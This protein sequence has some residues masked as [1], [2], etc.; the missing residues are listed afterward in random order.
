MTAVEFTLCCKNAGLTV[1]EIN[2]WNIG[3]IIDYIRMK[4]K[5]MM[6][7]DSVY[8]DE[9]RYKQLKAIEPKV[10]EDYKKGLITKERYDKFK[11]QLSEWR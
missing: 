10:D 9:E 8:T 1:E 4:T 7:N 3:T 11:R 2:E 5:S 6:K